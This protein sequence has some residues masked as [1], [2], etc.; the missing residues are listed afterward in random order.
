M[1][2]FHASAIPGIIPGI[3]SLTTP[4]DLNAAGVFAGE[5]AA[6]QVSAD[7]FHVHACVGT[8]SWIS[9]LGALGADHNSSGHA[10]NNSGF[11]VGYSQTSHWDAPDPYAHAVFSNG[12]PPLVDLHPTLASLGFLDSVAWD[13]NDGGDIVGEGY[14]SLDPR[15]SHAWHLR[16]GVATDLTAT[17]DAGIISARAINNNR[18]ITGQVR[19]GDVFRTY[20]YDLNSSVLTVASDQVLATPFAINDAGVA[21][22]QEG[23]LAFMLQGG[24]SMPLGT[25]GG[26]GSIGLGINAG[27]RVVGVSDLVSNTIGAFLYDAS[28]TPPPMIDLSKETA[29]NWEVKLVYAINDNGRMVGIGVDDGAWHAIYLGPPG[30]E[31]PHKLPGAAVSVL[32]ILAGIIQDG[33]GFYIGHDGKIH[34]VGPGPGDP[35]PIW[36]RLTPAEIDGLLRFGI[37]ELA[38]AIS[39]PGLRARVTHALAPVVARTAPARRAV[40]HGHAGGGPVDLAAG[41][42]RLGAAHGLDKFARFQAT[43][44][45]PVAGPTRHSH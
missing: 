33:A 11:V 13:I 40:A 41:T 18:Q 25:L 30:P 5:A 7:S 34:P 14:V 24:Q 38:S 2:K 26:P 10:I 32:T 42:R 28:A 39:D 37:G 9:D 15:V 4:Y 23:A 19:A 16:N 6:V 29:G 17:V 8:P 21:V 20:V 44:L 31:P 35:G 36:K 3:E 45:G 12:A 27:N 43:R 22:G 1:A